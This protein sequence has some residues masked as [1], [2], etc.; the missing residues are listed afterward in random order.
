MKIS[1]QKSYKN[2]K[3]FTGWKQKKKQKKCKI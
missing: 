2:M 3:V 1:E